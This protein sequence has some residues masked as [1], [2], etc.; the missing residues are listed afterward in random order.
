MATTMELDLPCVIYC[1]LKKQTWMERECRDEEV[2][3]QDIS[4]DNQLG[5]SGAS[6]VGMTVWV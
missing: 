5:P 6:G 1:M 2:F 4:L 3:D